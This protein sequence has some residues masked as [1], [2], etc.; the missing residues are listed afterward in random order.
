MTLTIPTAVL[1]KTEESAHLLVNDVVS[2]T[3][4]LQEVATLHENARTE[5]ARLANDLND[6][7]DFLTNCH[8]QGRVDWSAAFWDVIYDQLSTVTMVDA[9]IL[10]LQSEREL[11]ALANPAIQ[12]D[13]NAIPAAGTLE[14]PI[15]VQIDGRATYPTVIDEQ[16][17]QRFITNKVLV[18]MFELARQAG[19]ITV[20][21]LRVM[22]DNGHYSPED[23]RAFIA[24]TMGLTVNEFQQMFPGVVVSNPMQPDDDADPSYTFLTSR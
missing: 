13:A 7:A 24:Q 4:H 18:Q 1:A 16:G 14:H 5:Q 12:D 10:D 15:F 20:D 8:H 17:Q 19:V 6:L 23:F 9:G 3:L 21:S 11:E 22:S 2:A